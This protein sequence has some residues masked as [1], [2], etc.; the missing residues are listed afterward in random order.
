MDRWGTGDV[1]GHHDVF[2]GIPR[3]SAYRAAL[4]TVG[5]RIFVVSPEIDAEGVLSIAPVDTV[6]AY[7]ELGEITP[8]ESGQGIVGAPRTARTPRGFAVA[9]ARQPAPTSP[10]VVLVQSVDCCVE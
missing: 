6:T 4:Q 9:W 2:V 7:D 10:T 1:L 8:L 5:E 3:G